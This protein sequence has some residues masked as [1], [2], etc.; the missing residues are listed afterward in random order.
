M[1]GDS[2]RV[3]LDS[4]KRFEIGEGVSRESSSLSQIFSVRKSPYNGSTQLTT[5][6]AS[7]PNILSSFFHPTTDCVFRFESRFNSTSNGTPGFINEA[8]IHSLP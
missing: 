3:E 8:V 1:E 7:D 2:I 4:L 6:K 5:A